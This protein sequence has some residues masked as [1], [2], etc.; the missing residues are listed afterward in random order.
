MKFLGVGSGG[1]CV[2]DVIHMLVLFQSHQEWRCHPP[3][4]DN[5][6]RGKPLL[7]QQGNFISFHFMSCALRARNGTS[8][9]SSL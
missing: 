8:A 1:W 6:F 3:L 5:S 4:E 2:Q 9:Q 7:K